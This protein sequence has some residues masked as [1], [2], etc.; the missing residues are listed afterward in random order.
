[1]ILLLKGSVI[2]P[3]NRI[4]HLHTFI[5]SYIVYFNKYLL[6]YGMRKV[7]N[8]E[9]GNKLKRVLLKNKFETRLSVDQRVYLRR[10]GLSI[11]AVK[12]YDYL[13]S[14]GRLT[15]QDASRLTQDFPSAHYRL[16]YELESHKLVRKIQGRPVAFAALPLQL[17]FKFSFQNNMRE[18]HHLSGIPDKNNKSNPE[19]DTEIIVGRQ[20]LYD[21][22]E[23]L[24]NKAKHEICLFSIGIAYS[25][26]LEKTQRSAI[27]RG[28][29]IKHVVQQRKLSN[30]HVIAKW[31]RIGVKLRHLKT[32]RGFHFFVIDRTNVCIT[33]SEPEDTENR[34][35]VI[36]NNKSATE[37]FVSQFHDI[38]QRANV[39]EY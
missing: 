26:R 1:M 16:F 8:K 18:L 39:I 4:R 11:G 27:K 34:L 19:A 2:E 17:G 32:Q 28:I 5:N 12:L 38:W 25:V 13:L 35:S 6:K 10:I 22:Y 23:R 24:A 7:N 9:P 36:T 14:A 15:A 3:T 31:L 33:F 30:Q 37:L 21:A 20:S 29:S